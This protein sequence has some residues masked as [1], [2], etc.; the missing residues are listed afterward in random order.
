MEGEIN[1]GVKVREREEP[2]RT[3]W[4]QGGL[5]I[6]EH[7]QDGEVAGAGGAGENSPV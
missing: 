6:T 1:I 3:P 5:K 7:C 2:T 4:F